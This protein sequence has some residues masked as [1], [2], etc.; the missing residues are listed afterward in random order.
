MKKRNPRRRQNTKKIRKKNTN[1]VTGIETITAVIVIA[2]IETAIT[3]ITKNTKAVKK[4]RKNPIMRK[5]AKLKF[6]LILIQITNLRKFVIIGLNP[7]R[8]WPRPPQ[9]GKDSKTI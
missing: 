3:T 9:Q 5:T 8:P 7:N 4:K 6:Q 2:I 1:Q